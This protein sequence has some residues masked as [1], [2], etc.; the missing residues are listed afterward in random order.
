M[1]NENGDQ[2]AL[3]PEVEITTEE[4]TEETQEEQ[5]DWE[6]KAKKAEELAQNYKIRAEKAEKAI[7]APKENETPKNEISL[8]DYKALSDVHEEDIED[9]VEYAS[10]KKISLAEAKKTD[11]VKSLLEKKAEQRQVALSANI[12][13][14]RRVANKDTGVEILQK[15]E[16]TGQLPESDDE[17]AKLAKAQFERKLKK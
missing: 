13:G 4:T 2:E 16:K 7:K 8:K 17:I 5:V 14:S 9:L 15:F 11:F 6:A 1:E 12:N 10:F 3:N